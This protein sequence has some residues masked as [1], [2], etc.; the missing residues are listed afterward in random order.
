MLAFCASEQKGAMLMLR[1]V[2]LACLFFVGA[3]FSMPTVG[4]EYNCTMPTVGLKCVPSPL[5]RNPPEKTGPLDITACRSWCDSNSAQPGPGCCSWSHFDETCYLFTNSSISSGPDYVYSSTCQTVPSPPA[6]PGPPTY[7]C[8]Q[9]KCV[10][11]TPGISKDV[12]AK[13]CS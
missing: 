3:S 5:D 9:G 11:G 10:P 6:P 7:K 13:V 4:S 2:G 12:C 1:S 8:V